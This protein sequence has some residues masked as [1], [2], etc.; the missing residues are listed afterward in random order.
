M[1]LWEITLVYFHLSTYLLYFI[2]SSLYTY[3]HTSVVLISIYYTHGTLAELFAL[4]PV[5]LFYVFVQFI[6]NVK[7]FFDIYILVLFFSFPAKPSLA[8]Y[9]YV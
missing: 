3:R 9:Y 7:R 5:S 8:Y 2:F 4:R 6:F 1:P